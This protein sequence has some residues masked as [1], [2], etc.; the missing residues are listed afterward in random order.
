MEASGS[1]IGG[2]SGGTRGGGDCVVG[3]S[4]VALANLTVAVVTI[5]CDATRGG[6]SRVL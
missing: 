6:V 4:G 5:V 1:G 3:S 2:G